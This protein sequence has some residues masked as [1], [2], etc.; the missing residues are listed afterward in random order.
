MF[1][2]RVLAIVRARQLNLMGGLAAGFV[3]EAAAGTSDLPEPENLCKRLRAFQSAD[4][5]DFFG[6]EDLTG[7]LVERLGR[8]RFLAVVGLS[9]NSSLVER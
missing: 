4:E 3:P 1:A 7:K 9:G 6:R 5:R 2:S 8:V